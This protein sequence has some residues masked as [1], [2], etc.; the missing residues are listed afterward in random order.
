[1]GRRQVLQWR[2]QSR[3]QATARHQMA[4]ISLAAGPALPRKRVPCLLKS[5]D[6]GSNRQ[7]QSCRMARTPT[8]PWST[9]LDE[10]GSKAC[11]GTLQKADTP[12]DEQMLRQEQAFQKM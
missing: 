7:S 2:Q 6:G 9:A 5:D 11:T 1:M 4:Q 10:P 3:M 12:I 8:S